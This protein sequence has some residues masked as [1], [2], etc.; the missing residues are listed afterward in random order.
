[1]SILLSKIKYIQI[2]FRAKTFNVTVPSIVGVTTISTL[3]RLRLAVLLRYQVRR[4]KYF[5]LT[6]VEV[7]P[8]FDFF[9]DALHFY[10]KLLVYQFWLLFYSPSSAG[11]RHF[12]I[13]RFFDML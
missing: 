1:M 9:L 5:L 8:N 2:S 12:G 10:F 13:G 11:E 7:E 4:R 6:P 3:D